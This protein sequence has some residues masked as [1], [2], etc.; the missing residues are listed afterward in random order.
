MR[1]R[2][3]L[4]KFYYYY[5]GRFFPRRLCTILYKKRIGREINWSNP[6]TFNEWVCWLE[7]YSDTSLW[8]IL[9]D[10]YKVR[11]Y[12]ESKGLGDYLPKLYGVYDNVN[13]IDFNALPD[14]FVIKANNGCAQV[15]IVK[16]KRTIK[17]EHIKKICRKWLKTT[18]GYISAEPHYVK[19]PKRIIIEELIEDPDNSSLIDYKWFCF[20]GRPVYAQVVSER[21]F[22]EAHKFRL[23]VYDTDWNPHDEFLN[24]KNLKNNVNK[25]ILLNEQLEIC[26][27][28]S[29]G[30][31]QIRIDL[32]EVK[33]K[34]YIGELTL[35]NAAGRDIDMTFEFDQ[36]LGKEIDK[37][38]IKLK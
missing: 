33:G 1:I 9:A 24:R 32:Y 25:P 5:L 6:T 13:E 3:I 4:A 15:I 28:L 29:Q 14:K 16:D 17:E 34:V 8:T 22:S 26:R 18:F 27:I 35:T 10:K 37:S 21:D 20:N 11:E 2:S 23:Q 38:I 7:F 30:F 12:I 36:I 19:I 31:P